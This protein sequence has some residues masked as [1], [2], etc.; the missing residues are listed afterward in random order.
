MQPEHVAIIRFN[1]EKDVSAT[2]DG[3]RNEVKVVKNHE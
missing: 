2:V 1:E 3:A